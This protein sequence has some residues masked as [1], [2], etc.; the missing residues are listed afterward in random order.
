MGYISSLN[1]QS[2]DTFIKNQSDINSVSLS[3]GRLNFHNAGRVLRDFKIGGS[4]TLHLNTLQGIAERGGIAQ[5]T[6]T[7][8]NPTII[9]ENLQVQTQAG[10]PSTV[11]SFLNAQGTS[12]KIQIDKVIIDKVD[13]QTKIGQSIP[14]SNIVSGIAQN[15][16][17]FVRDADFSEILK[18][19]GFYGKYNPITGILDTNFDANLGAL[20]IF[21]QVFIEQLSNRA[22]FYDAML[23]E[24]DRAA[25]RYKVTQPR[26]NYDLFIR[27]Y[28]S[29]SKVDIEKLEGDA[30]GQST[31]I[32]G[33]GHYFL[34][35]S[36][37]A[38][39]GV[40]EKNK[41]HLDDD[42]LN[43]NHNALIFGAKYSSL[44]SLDAYYYGATLRS[45]FSWGDIH[46]KLF[47]A[48]ASKGRLKSYAY[49]TKFY[50]GYNLHRDGIDVTEY[51]TPELALGYFGGIIKAFEMK[52]GPYRESFDD[53][54]YNVLYTQLNL[55]WFK[56]WQYNFAT[57]IDGG[58]RW[59]VNNNINTKAQINDTKF[60]NHFA[61]SRH[62]VQLGTTAMFI[63]PGGVDLSLAYKLIESKNAASHNVSLK[64]H[65][66]F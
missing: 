15:A 40:V 18:K 29:V 7:Q 37:L 62:Y 6:I 19:A 10:I 61:L 53:A 32:I 25:L 31:G 4:S 44:S 45:L 22:V 41:N 8:G 35:T 59:N 54:N 12:P 11:V 60:F 52:G 1:A 26:T 20:G 28:V 13:A 56:R 66:T 36:L 49:G 43:F 42:F 51:L 24:L 65:K 47:A 57:Q 46:R 55:S 30:K 3:S 27:P 9:I 58:L 39:Y 2:G 48:S 50:I 17:S 21:S 64:F 34:D 14:L 16:S 63:N 23:L 38:L 5:I 33:G